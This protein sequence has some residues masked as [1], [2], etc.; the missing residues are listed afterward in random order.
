MFFFVNGHGIHKTLMH[1]LDMLFLHINTMAHSSAVHSEKKVHVAKKFS[2]HVNYGNLMTCL[3]QI[4]NGNN[5]QVQFTICKLKQTRP[6]PCQSSSAI[7][8]RSGLQG[9]KT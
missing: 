6:M 9:R 5:L 8:I 3:F 2:R 4:A 7:S 1:Y